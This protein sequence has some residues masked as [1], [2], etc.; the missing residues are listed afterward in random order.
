[1]QI[2]DYSYL[3]MRLLSRVTAPNATRRLQVLILGL[4]PHESCLRLKLLPT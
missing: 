2:I 4:I 3:C 1:M